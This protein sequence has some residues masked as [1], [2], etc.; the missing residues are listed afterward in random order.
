[1]GKAWIQLGVGGDPMMFK[2]DFE[3]L[4]PSEKERFIRWRD[5]VLSY[6]RQDTEEGELEASLKGDRIWGMCGCNNDGSLYLPSLR[7]SPDPVMIE[8]EICKG[9]FGDFDWRQ[10]IHGH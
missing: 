3:K 4:S 9:M 1:M 2:Q 8:D 5:F 10:E 6:A 7:L